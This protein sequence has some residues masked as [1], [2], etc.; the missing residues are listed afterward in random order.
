[1]RLAKCESQF[2]MPGN[3]PVRFS[4]SQPDSQCCVQIAS[5]QKT[6]SQLASGCRKLRVPSKLLA[7]AAEHSRKHSRTLW[8]HFLAH[9]DDITARKFTNTPGRRLDHTLL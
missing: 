6:N 4:D 9:D 8:K 7:G 2:G 3:K 5:V 1:M